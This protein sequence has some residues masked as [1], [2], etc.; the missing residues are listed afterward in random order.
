[1]PSRLPRFLVAALVLAVSAPLRGQT[2]TEAQVEAI[3]AGAEDV[4]LPSG[5]TVA[6]I[7]G[8]RDLPLVAA[9][10]NGHGPYRLLVDLGSNVVLLRRDVVDAAGVTILVDRDRSDLVRI[11]SLRIGDAVWAPVTAGAYDEL[12]VDGVVG[13]NLLR[14]SPFTLD[15]PGRRLA[16]HRDSLPASDGDRVLDYIVTDRLPYLPV[17]VADTTL[18]FNFD[19]GAVNAIVMPPPTAAALEWT[20]PERQGPTLY[21]NQTGFQR[22]GIRRLAGDVTFGRYRVPS[23]VVFVDPDVE[24]PWFGAVLLADYRIQFDTVRLRL[25][26]DGPD[27]ASAPP[28]CGAGFTLRTEGDAARVADIV[29]GT[30]AEGQLRTGDR[31]VDVGGRPAPGLD[32]RELR[33]LACEADRIEIRREREG[34]VESLT[35]P[36]ARIPD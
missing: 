35:V 24:T 4:R 16:L 31:I 7:L 18:L 1:M 17:R 23:P 33:A 9:W 26:I 5:G 30:P 6:P 32:A 36:T 8:P 13:Y 2:L 25:R 19:T 21:N 28:W 20:G 27:L 12:D 3:R 11:D 22:V 14:L 15:F 34:A 29:P 10:I